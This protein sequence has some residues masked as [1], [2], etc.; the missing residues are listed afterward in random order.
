[1]QHWTDSWGNSCAQGY[2]SGSGV[3]AYGQAQASAQGPGAWELNPP[4]AHV[5]SS[6]QHSAAGYQISGGQRG[7]AASA[8]AYSVQG[9]GYGPPPAAA[10]ATPGVQGYGASPA[11]AGAAQLQS[12]PSGAST[13]QTWAAYY[14]GGG[15]Q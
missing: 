14:A 10:A 15:V 4:A 9:L 5:H 3:A 13:D 1:M 12:Q 6:W 2:Q 8:Q 7:A 11:W